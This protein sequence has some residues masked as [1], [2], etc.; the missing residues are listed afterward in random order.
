MET[1]ARRRTFYSNNFERLSSSI[2]IVYYRLAQ[3][4]QHLPLPHELLI[5]L[6]KPWMTIELH[7]V[8]SFIFF[9]QARRG[10]Y[11]MAI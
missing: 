11:V 7:L 3:P 5:C 4:T 10:D 1:L 2:I 6:V 8:V 9:T